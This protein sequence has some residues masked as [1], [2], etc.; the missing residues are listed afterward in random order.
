[1]VAVN[2][3]AAPAIEII[4][5]RPQGQPPGL[6]LTWVITYAGRRRILF[7]ALFA[8]GLHIANVAMRDAGVKPENIDIAINHLIASHPE[9]RPNG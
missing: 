9:E 3:S 4:A 5:I 1:M 7:S 8:D 6:M 2:N